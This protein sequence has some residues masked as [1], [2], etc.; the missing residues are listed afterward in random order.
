MPMLAWPNYSK[1]MSDDNKSNKDE[2]RGGKRGGD[3]RVPPRTYIIWIA[4]LGAIPLLMVF[5]STGPTA[6]DHLT[7]IQFQQM[8]DANRIARGKIVY[9][10]QS[11][12]LQEI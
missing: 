9:D 1:I 8:V 3:F 2:C 7:Q 6:A 11:P 5:K 4:I 10:P 12:Y